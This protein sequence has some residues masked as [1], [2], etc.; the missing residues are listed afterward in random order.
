MACCASL[1]FT[2]AFMSR[3]PPAAAQDQS[4]VASSFKNNDSDEEAPRSASPGA[5][6]AAAAFVKKT[7]LGTGSPIE[8][9]GDEAEPDPPPPLSVLENIPASSF[10]G[11][12]D[13][14]Q[15][16]SGLPVDIRNKG[17]EEAALSYGAR[18][19][20]AWRTYQIRQDI[21][22]RKA[23][24]DKVFDFRGLLIPAPSGLL[25][26]PP[27]ITE[28]DDAMTCP[29]C[30]PTAAAVA[31]RVYEINKEARF[32]NA[33][34]HWRNYLEREWG[35]VTPPPDMLRPANDKERKEWIEW[36]DK[37]WKKGIQQADEIFQDDLNQLLRDYR[38]M[39][40][41]RMLLAQGMIT[42]P[43]AV[44]LDRGVTSNRSEMRV[45]DR[46][47]HI[48]VLPEFNTETRT[49]KPANR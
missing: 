35:E 38:G 45:G 29:D 3:V 10:S 43:Y 5:Q 6:A 22:A 32:V 1:A 40:R 7:Y 9:P 19:G 33:P 49:W 25:I 30:A 26:E 23:Y 31:D 41:Y 36:V 18:G 28:Q 27:V 20:L 4:A 13:N 11:K 48:T 14:I 42:P 15:K 16:N 46:E 44:Q 8:L 34:R 37:G 24:M 39:V 21:D 17:M 12:I 47:V 2:A